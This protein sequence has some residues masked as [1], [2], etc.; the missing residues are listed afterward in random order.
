MGGDVTTRPRR[1]T[2][3]DP[4]LLPEEE[5][6][7]MNLQRLDVE[8]LRK[9]LQSASLTNKAARQAI[10]D[11]LRRVDAPPA[12][13]DDSRFKPLAKHRS[14]AKDGKPDAVVIV[15]PLSTGATLAAMASARGF[16]IVRVLSQAFPEEIANCLP[17]GLTLNWHASLEYDAEDPARTV[18]ALRSLDAHVLG[19]LVGCECGVECHDA[20]TSALRGHASNGPERSLARRDKHPM[21]EAVRHAGLRAVKQ[22]LCSG[23]AAAKAFCE[24]L[25]VNDY[26][27]ES[28][29]CVLK[30]CRSAGTDGVYIAKSMKECEQRFGE[31]LGTD[32][33]FGDPN[34]AVLVQEFMKGTE[35]VVDHVSV[36]GVHKCVA[37]WRYDKRP[38]NGAQFVYYA[39]ELYQSDDGVMESKLTEYVRG[40]LDALGCRH[41]PSHAE[42]MWLD[43]CDEPCLVEVGCRPHGGEGTFVELSSP[44]IGYDQLSVMLDLVERPYRVHRLP[45]RPAPFTGGAV[46][47]MLIAHASGILRRINMEKIRALASY[48]GEEIKI[49]VG[50]DLPLT[51]DFLCTPGSVMLRS[52]DSKQLRA[53]TDAIHELCIDGLFEIEK[54]SQIRLRG[55]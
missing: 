4:G 38:C 46:E 14:T 37:I 36:E 6:L 9:V 26:T 49:K 25:G 39:M 48:V 40:V 18:E 42:V 10:G 52:A 2:F 7:V 11:A 21:G 31:I 5:S 16:L 50:S 3:D 55:L 53:D 27:K 44:T 24:G 30:P 28:A 45:A 33:V 23:W 35:Y 29:W 20:L 22:E 19:V 47:V 15:D 12:P 43:S 1:A 34:D 13:P 41:G 51:V 17:D 8:T 32:T 54:P